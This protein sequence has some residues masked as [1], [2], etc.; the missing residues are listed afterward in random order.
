MAI[1]EN[2]RRGASFFRNLAGDGKRVTPAFIAL[3]QAR[4]A[5]LKGRKFYNGFMWRKPFPAVAW[6]PGKPGLAYVE[7]LE[8]VGLRL[9][10]E[11]AGLAMRYNRSHHGYYTNNEGESF[12]DGSGLC[13]GVVVLAPHGRYYPGYQFGGFDSGPTVDFRRA[14]AEAD[15]CKGIADSMAEN[16]AETER[17]YQE[18]HA[19][20]RDCAETMREVAE[21][22]RDWIADY[23]RLRVAFCERW[24]AVRDDV[25]MSQTREWLRQTIAECRDGRE[26]YRT[27][28]E[29]VF[30]MIDDKKP[31]RHDKTNRDSFW[32]G[33]A[34]G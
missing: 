33:F 28:R 31:G 25:P 20:G 8:R 12:K 11:N 9:A 29:K 22:G 1:S 14:Y 15:D 32:E 2:V 34:N 17:E 30:S 23:R 3:N 10:V 27:A 24:Q 13:W 16:A 26:A 4:E 5:D 6:Q 18:A 19:N 7:C 21:L